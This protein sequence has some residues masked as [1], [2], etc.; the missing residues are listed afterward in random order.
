MSPC[1]RWAGGRCRGTRS[2]APARTSRRWSSDWRA[3]VARNRGRSLVSSRPASGVTQLYKSISLKTWCLAYG[4]VL[5]SIL[6][7]MTAV[8]IDLQARVRL[9]HAA[10]Q[11]LAEQHG[12]DL[13]HVKGPALDASLSR[14]D[15]PSSDADV[16]VR[17]AQVEAFT[18]HLRAHGWR[19]VTDFASGSAFEHAAN[20]HHGHW[21]YVDVH[22][23]FPGITLEPDE[24][25]ELLWSER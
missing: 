3:S 21:G 22:R 13:L 18:A 12:I 25:F 7:S 23:V 10:V 20:Y 15:R 2:R 16:L 9:A 6:G 19:L 14:P 1:R 4:P 24:A 11:A 17:P 5:T 8:P